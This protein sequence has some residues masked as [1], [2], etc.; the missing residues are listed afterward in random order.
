MEEKLTIDQVK[1][2]ANQQISILYKK[3]EEANLTNAYKRLDYLFE[4]VKNQFP[5]GMKETAYKE[6]D[7]IMFGESKDAGESK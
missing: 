3:L 5:E 1:A 4:I 7:S 2:A 6:I